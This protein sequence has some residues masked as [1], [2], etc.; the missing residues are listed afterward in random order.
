MS[1]LVKLAVVGAAAGLAAAAWAAASSRKRPARALRPQFVLFGDSITQQGFQVGGWVSRFAATYERTADIVS[2]G[3]SGYNTRWV[4]PLLPTIF[5]EGGAAPALVTVLLGAND[6]ARPPPVPGLPLT[7]ANGLPFAGRQHVPL[8]EYRA[9]LMEIVACIR[10]CG[11][12]GARVL[13]ITPPV[14]GPASSSQPGRS[15]ASRVARPSRAPFL[16]CAHS[17]CTRRTGSPR[18]ARGTPTRPPTPNPSAPPP[19][20]P[21]RAPNPPAPQ[22]RPQVC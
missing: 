12:G 4:L 15:A 18:S 22:Q 3:F 2:R 1:D 11:G 8:D 13:L 14:A 10:K 9:N 6:A 16:P 17:P 20:P 19:P 5:P 21:L 7:G